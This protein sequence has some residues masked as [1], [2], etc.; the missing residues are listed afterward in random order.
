MHR[1]LKSDL[2]LSKA[3]ARWVPRF[4]SVEDCEHNPASYN[5]ENRPTSFIFQN[6]VRRWLRPNVGKISSQ[7]LLF[8]IF[9]SKFAW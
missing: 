5:C 9:P 7:T 4:L 6:D 1:I 3:S 2:K 8:D